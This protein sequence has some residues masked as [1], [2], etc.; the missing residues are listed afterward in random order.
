VKEDKDEFFSVEDDDFVKHTAEGKYLHGLLDQLASA[1]KRSLTA[2]N[3]NFKSIQEQHNTLVEAVDKTFGMIDSN[4][5]AA[6]EAINGVFKKI[7]EDVNFLRKD[8]GILHEV[9]NDIDNEKEELEDKIS[10]L[11]DRIDEL[12]RRLNERILG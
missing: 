7:A 4:F 12:N 11:E 2:A 10:R 9:C 3:E 1:T 5:Q 8:S 6:E